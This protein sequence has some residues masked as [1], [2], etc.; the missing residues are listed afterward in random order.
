MKKTIT[1][2]N[3]NIT[4]NDGKKED[5]VAIL[6]EYLWAELCVYFRELEALRAKHDNMI[7]KLENLQALIGEIE[8]A[9]FATAHDLALT[10]TRASVKKYVEYLK[11]YKGAVA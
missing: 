6:P 9:D 10:E 3:L 1:M 8:S 5:L 2:T 7:N 4:W 11:Q